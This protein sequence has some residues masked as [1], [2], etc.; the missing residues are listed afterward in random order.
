MTTGSL[1]P[2]NLTAL[3]AKVTGDNGAPFAALLQPKHQAANIAAVASTAATSTTP[4]GYAEAQA[5]AIVTNINAIRT[6]L[7]NA[8]IMKAS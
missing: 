5:N 1:N 8:G 4:F 2:T 7:I 3:N 6:A